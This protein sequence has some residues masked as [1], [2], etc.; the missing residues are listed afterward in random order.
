MA[1]AYWSSSYMCQLYKSSHSQG[2]T[3]P[4]TCCQITTNSFH[5]S[6][7]LSRR[8]N[9]K[10]PRKTSRTR[11]KIHLQ[12][13]NPNRSKT[14]KLHQAITNSSLNH[15]FTSNSTINEYIQPRNCNKI[16]KILRYANHHH[17]TCLST[18]RVRI[19]H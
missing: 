8:S 12:P 17:Q 14:S 13:S 16:C 2:S 5:F 9:T 15:Q 7:S 4:F 10:K 19:H 6:L 1:V 11:L 3:E 18:I